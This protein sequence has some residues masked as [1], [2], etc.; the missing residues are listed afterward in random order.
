MAGLSFVEID[1]VRAGSWTLPDHDGQLRLPSER[2]SH[3]VCVTR[4]GVRWRHEFYVCPLREWLPVIRVPLRRGERDAALD[5]QELVNQS[6]ER[7]RYG[8]KIDYTQPPDPPMPPEDWTWA[9]GIL[10]AGR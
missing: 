7:G 10:A 6:Y 1:L 2:V 4:S 5:L 9:Q 8:R 3:V